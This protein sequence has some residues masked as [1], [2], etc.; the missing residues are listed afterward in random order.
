LLLASVAIIGCGKKSESPPEIPFAAAAPRQWD[1]GDQILKHK[2]PDDIAD[3]YLE[4]L[5]SSGFS[6]G[7]TLAHERISLRSHEKSDMLIYVHGGV[8]RFHIADKDLTAS[9]GDVVYV[10]R[11]AA[12]SAQSLSRRE[13]ELLTLYAPPLD[14]D[15][16]K[17][18]EPAVRASTDSLNTRKPLRATLGGSDSLR[19]PDDE[20]RNYLNM[21]DYQEEEEGGK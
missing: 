7:V 18:L 20:E 9:M 2:L 8:A 3:G 11:G 12:Y 14:K 10:P 1:I 15:D 16:V 13:L 19:P 5:R 17:F 6:Y 4:F 21:K